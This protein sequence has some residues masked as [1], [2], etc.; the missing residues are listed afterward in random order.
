[1]TEINR[2]PPQKFLGLFRLQ[3]LPVRTVNQSFVNFTAVVVP[4]K[5]KVKDLKKAIQRHL[6]L[7]QTR[8][9]GTTYISWYGASVSLMYDL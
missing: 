8:E 4:L 1:M 6:T 5:A 9:G 7:K 3:L 2:L